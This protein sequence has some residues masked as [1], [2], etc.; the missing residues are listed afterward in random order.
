MH[1]MVCY[2]S[3]IFQFFAPNRRCDSTRTSQNLRTETLNPQFRYLQSCQDCGLSFYCSDQHWDAVRQTHSEK[4]CEDGHDGISQCD[5]N[6]EIRSDI[7]F[8]NTTAAA[9]PTLDQFVW[10]PERIKPSWT[11]LDGRSWQGEYEADVA[12]EFRIPIGPSVGPYIRAVSNALSMPMTI[13]WALENL[14]SDDTWTHKKK[15]T[16]HVCI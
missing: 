4:P 8:S 11:P 1:G 5:L 2:S 15:L 7:A 12:R 6:Q 9:S 3:R 10:A 16:I 14:H 13:L